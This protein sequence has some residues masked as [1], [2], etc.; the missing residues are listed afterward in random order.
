MSDLLGGEARV[1]T[2]RAQ[3]RDKLMT[4]AVTVFADR[5]I[6]GASVEEICEAAGF[7]RGAFYS[8]FPDKDALVL[9]LIRHEV[10]IQ[11][12]AAER[13]VE[14]MKVA[15]SAGRSAEEMVDV[16]LRAFDAGG[17]SGRE[18]ILT[19]QELRLYAAREP[20]VRAQYLSFDRECA[21]Q[22]STLIA[23][24]V[25]H[26]GREFTVPFE[27]AISLLRAT[28]NEVQM[29]ALFGHGEVDSHRLRVLLLAITRPA[30][31]SG[32]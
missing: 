27:D 22:F 19:Q 8:N 2:R 20:G 9:E 32:H 28:H 15:A 13:A 12:T 11:Y 21:K 18:W 16:A 23:D 30:T 1:T 7:T 24:A 6:I 17:R 31:Q 29:E 4:A 14:V 3:T 25:S 26:A 5:G 10:E